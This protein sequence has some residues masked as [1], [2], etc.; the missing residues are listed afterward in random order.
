MEFSFKAG[1]FSESVGKYPERNCHSNLQG[2]CSS[3]CNDNKS[4]VNR[5]LMES[6]ADGAWN[7]SR[8][9]SVRHW[10]AAPAPP[11][12]YRHWKIRLFSSY[13]R[14]QPTVSLAVLLGIW[15]FSCSL[16]G[17]QRNLF[18]LNLKKIHCCL[19]LMLRIMIN[20]N[21]KN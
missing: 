2:K 20:W 3:S 13:H 19:C 6:V 8:G 17:F 18:C 9:T 7:P 10:Q 1:L 21:F 15:I 4:F 12:V 16:L 14:P 5:H 11:Q